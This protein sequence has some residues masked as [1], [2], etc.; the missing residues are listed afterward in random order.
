[1]KNIFI[2]LSV[3]TIVLF[4][5]VYARAIAL[6]AGNPA[7]AFKVS[8]GDNKELSLDD[9]KGKVAVI[10]YETKDT[11]EKN[12]QLKDELNKF[13]GVQPDSLKESIL[14]IPV[15]NCKGVIFTGIWKDSL[16]QNSQKESLTIYGDWDGKM[17]SAY[18][19]PDNESNLIIVGKD[20]IIKYFFTGRVEEK[21]FS[22]IKGL[23]IELGN[24]SGGF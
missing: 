8:S 4:S 15:I 11:K 22:R 2:W 3:L 20:G 12:R 23:L 14:R 16:K 9:L 5:A 17:F 19:I 13:Y 21:N 10:F 6:E 24:A 18:G 7:P 1:M